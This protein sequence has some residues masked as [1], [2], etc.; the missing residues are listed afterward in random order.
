M[1]R[2][3]AASRWSGLRRRRDSEPKPKPSYERKNQNH[4][5]SAVQSRL[6]LVGPEAVAHKSIFQGRRPV[7]PIA[8]Q[9]TPAGKDPAS[10]KKGE[11]SYRAHRRERQLF[12]LI[13]HWKRE[14]ISGSFCIGIKFRFQAHSTIGK[15]YSPHLEGGKKLRALT[16]RSDRVYGVAKLPLAVALLRAWKK[17][18]LGTL[19]GGSTGRSRRPSRRLID[20]MVVAI[21][22]TPAKLLSK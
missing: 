10:D 17:S 14:A 6:P 9:M 21:E 4:L 2:S 3:M 19:A 16:G 22:R 15:C 11:Y 13:D 12:R 1:I 18:S 7:Y 20:S 5:S 8:V